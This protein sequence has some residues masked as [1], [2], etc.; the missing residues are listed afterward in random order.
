MLTSKISDVIPCDLTLNYPLLKKYPPFDVL[1][2]SFCV[3]VVATDIG[4]FTQYLKNL[5]S[6][7]KDDSYIGMLVSIE[8]SY[9]IVKGGKRYNNLFLTSDDVKKAFKESGFEIMRVKHL[10]IPLKSQIPTF[11]NCKALEHFVLR[12]LVI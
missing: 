3:E 7:L 9:F 6:L 10:D 12:K 11:S 4:K 2:I 5:R 1:S 8:E